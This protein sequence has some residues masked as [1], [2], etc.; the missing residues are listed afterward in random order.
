MT[1]DE[2]L[3]AFAAALDDVEIRLASGDWDGVIGSDITTAVVDKPTPAQRAR[4]EQLLARWGRC[5]GRLRASL[6]AT[7]GELGEISAR[8]TAGRAYAWEGTG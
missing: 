6:T 8:R 2:A 1:F 5:R 3:D 7:R 4:A